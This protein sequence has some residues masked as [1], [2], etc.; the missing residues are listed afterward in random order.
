M[1]EQVPEENDLMIHDEGAVRVFTIH[2]PQRRNALSEALKVKFMNAILAAEEDEQI[3]VMLITGAGEQAFCAGADLKN[4]HQNDTLGVKFRTPMSR[5]ER[6]IFEV[7]FETKKPVIAALNGSAVAGGFELAMACN[8]RVAHPDVLLGL[9]ETKIG[10]GANFGS[11]LLPRLIG[12]TRA[13]ELLLTGEYISAAKAYE[14]GLINRLVAAP[15]VFTV[16]MELAQT[17]AH[18][19]PISVR[20]VKAVALRGLDLPVASALRQDLGQ[21]PYT[22]EDRQEGIT[23]RLEK[24][25]PVWKNR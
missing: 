12:I 11:V 16:A 19:A 15:E 13:L 6:N 2:R 5:L 10:M 14:W 17:I 25:A 4:M 8:L 20:R 3:R 18:N 24:R 21:N 23:A 1:T 7:V 22:S 9:P